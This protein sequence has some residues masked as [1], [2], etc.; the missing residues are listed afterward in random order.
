MFSKW[1]IPSSIWWM[2]GSHWHPVQS[3]I[4]RKLSV[5]AVTSH[6]ICHRFLNCKWIYSHWI[7]HIVSFSLIYDN[8]NNM[9]KANGA[10]CHKIW[11][12]LYF[13]KLGDIV[14][15][16]I[17]SL[18]LRKKKILQ[19]SSIVVLLF[20]GNLGRCIKTWNA[21]SGSRVAKLQL[22]LFA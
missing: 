9:L 11:S 4:V 13:C 22:R 1:H 19:K 5:I 6:E 21:S 8:S 12:L 15:V 3:L 2:A 10:M 7:F 20:H 14:W 16:K 17:L 18:C